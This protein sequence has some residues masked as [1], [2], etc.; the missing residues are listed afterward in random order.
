M[1]S[2]GSRA[3]PLEG[4]MAAGGTDPGRQREV[5]EDRYH[6]DQD[7]GL[8]IVVDGIGGQAA[9]GRAADVALSTIRAQLERS[10]GSITSRVRDAV[11][12][13]NNEIHRAASTRAEW[14]G[15]A[16]VLTVAC[17]E[18]GKATIGHVGDTRL[19][20]LRDGQIGRAHV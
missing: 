13:A 15:M 1:S 20:K 16:C 11:A 19:Y 8:F 14:K 18:Q 12:S 3:W 10:G 9:G 5:N 4:L 7:R 2:V 17:V 6:V